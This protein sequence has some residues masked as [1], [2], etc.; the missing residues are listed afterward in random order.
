MSEFVTACFEKLS[1][2]EES[3]CHIV[4]LY[5]IVHHQLYFFKE[6]NLGISDTIIKDIIINA[7]DS[8]EKVN[9]RFELLS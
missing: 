7:N 5:R 1:K 4:I 8:P 6:D 2:G 3:F 9:Q